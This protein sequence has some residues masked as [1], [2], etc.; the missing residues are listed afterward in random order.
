MAMKKFE[1]RHPKEMCPGWL[2]KYITITGGKLE[3]GKWIIKEILY[4]KTPLEPNQRWDQ[5]IKGNPVLIEKNLT[6]GK[7]YVVFRSGNPEDIEIIFAVEVNLNNGS[8]LV[9]TDTDLS[10]LNEN[11]YQIQRERV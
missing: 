9:L 6:T 1:E 7:E 5:D 10:L 2:N 3:K 8:V 11:D 4:K